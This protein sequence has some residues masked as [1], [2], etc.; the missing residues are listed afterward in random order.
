[1]DADH[2]V[3][4]FDMKLGELADGMI[5]TAYAG[6]GERYQRLDDKT[7][8]FIRHNFKRCS[9]VIIRNDS[10][11]TVKASEVRVGDT[12]LKVY[13]FPSNLLK[14]TQ[15]NS[16]LI[17]ALKYRDI[18]RFDIKQQAYLTDDSK[19]ELREIIKLVKQST[20]RL[21]VKEERRLES[22]RETNELIQ[23]TNESVNVR[24]EIISSVEYAMDNA[25]RGNNN[26][27]DI[28]KYVDGITQ[29]ASA[30]AMSAIA[31]IRASDQTYAHCVDVGV[32]FQTVYNY[33]LQETGR[34]SVFDSL[35]QAIL[36]AFLHDFGKAKV[37]K[38]LLDS[39]S[40]F[41]RSSKEM[42]ILMAHPEHG[43]KLLADM[44][45]PDSVINMAHYHHVK[46]DDNMLSSYPKDCH[47]EDVFFETRL[48][49]IVDVYQALVGRRRY[50]RSWSPPATMRYLDALS[51]VEYDYEVWLLFLKV[52]GLYPK[53]SV[54]EL[55]NHSIGFVVSIPR[56][57]SDPERPIVAV[58]RNEYGEDL[59]HH[60][61]VDLQEALDI[62]IAKD[63]DSLEVFGSNALDVFMGIEIS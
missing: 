35:N 49:A 63:L 36:S 15:V 22:I 19:R 17:K 43:A 53:G 58:V 18:R 29:T 34:K 37:P 4:K 45:L 42:Q 5:I 13:N 2:I 20:K 12:I 28:R 10:E 33:I 32:I 11:I 56:D 52:M 26:I 59:D 1:M 57:E 46:Q 55:S 7:S 61:L 14:L 44:G 47:Y 54:V 60:E 25:R 40:R 50:K 21:S 3:E 39:T 23:K 9:L 31:N 8:E 16:R 27:D 41:E 51:G 30:D 38:D 62:S 6:F 48:L 24:R